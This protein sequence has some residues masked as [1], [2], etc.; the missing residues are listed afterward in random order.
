M[1]K[2]AKINGLPASTHI[3][4]NVKSDQIKFCETND[5]FIFIYK[6]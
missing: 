3:Y 6:K 5:T 4:N 2:F 1:S